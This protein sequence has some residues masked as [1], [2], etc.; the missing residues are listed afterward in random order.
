MKKKTEKKKREKSCQRT[1]SNRGNGQEPYPKQQ[2]AKFWVPQTENELHDLVLCQSSVRIGFHAVAAR[3]VQ[4]FDEAQVQRSAT[5]L[6]A[7]ELCDC[8]LGGFN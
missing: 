6:I 8:R 1:E 7:L 3:L 5:I 2:W 4:I